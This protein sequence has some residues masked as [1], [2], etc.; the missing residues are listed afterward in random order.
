MDKTNLNKVL[1]KIWLSEQELLEV[2]RNEREAWEEFSREYK[3]EIE[4]DLKLLKNKRDKAKDEKLVWDS[5]LF[6]THNALVSRSFQAKNTIKIKGDKNGIEREV[7]ML[8][9][10][11]NEDNSWAEYKAEKYYLYNDKYATW[12]AVRFRSWWD[13]VYKKNIV[14]VVNPLTWVPDPNGDYFT[15]RY[16]FAWFYAIDS[17]AELKK[18]GIDTDSLLKQGSEAAIDVKERMQRLLG[19]YPNLFDLDVVDTYYHFTIIDGVKIWVKTAN[20]DSFILESWIV[21]PNNKKE[22]EN[23]EIIQF[24]FAFYYWKPDRDNPF[25][26]RPANYTRDVQLQ[27]AEIANLRLNKMRAEL[28]PM[29]LYNTDVVDKK[30]LNFWFNK[31][32]PVKMGMWGEQFNINNVLTP[33]QRDTKVD[34]SFQVEDSLDRQVEKSTSIWD[35]VQW[36]PTARKETLGTNNLVQTNTDINLQINEEIHSIWDEQWINLWFWGYYQNF[37][38]WDKKLVYAWG[39]TGKEAIMLKK[40]DFIYTWNLA[41]SIESSLWR[42]DRLRKELAATVQVTPLIMGQMDT[43]SDIKYKRF[44]AERAGIPIENIDEFL[45]DSPQML[46]QSMENNLLRDGIYVPITETDDHQQH[47]IA[48]WTNINTPEAQAHRLAHMMEITKQPQQVN[49]WGLDENA[50]MNS[51]ASQGMSQAQSQLTP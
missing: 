3:I 37:E 19:L 24:P 18:Q 40:K 38:D 7:K 41:I 15:G 10:T 50:M 44:V 23:P 9:A 14:D 2:V 46:L 36:T 43:A 49:E 26:D 22:E 27:K 32:I 28:Y 45:M 5:T 12:V 51:M 17:K 34:T 13:G 35:I 11:L 33:I 20:I 16:K 31:G 39:Q 8:N 29:Y 1:S 47:L 48:M 4:A 21:K 6:N 42:E 25:G 30:D